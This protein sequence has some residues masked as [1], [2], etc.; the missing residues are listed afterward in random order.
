MDYKKVIYIIVIS[1]IVLVIIFPSA[2][3][4][5]L[6]KNHYNS[7]NNLVKKYIIPNLPKN[8]KTILDVGSGSGA[9][10]HCLKTNLKT[11]DI[12]PLDIKDFHEYGDKPLIYNGE[13][14]PLSDNSYDTLTCL[15][16]LHHIPN[17]DKILNELIRVS[18]KRLI[19]MEDWKESYLDNILTNIHSLSSYGKC[20]NC[21]HSKKE[22]KNIFESKGLKIK[23][24]INI[25]KNI[26]PIYPVSRVL[27]ILNK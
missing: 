5:F 7:K 27:F 4:K 8:N 18:K 12:L 11:N 1:I 26:M 25:P 3:E 23:K 16:V 24:M 21:F 9:I 20:Q 17:Q 6:R 13:N 14:I 15:S 10:A 2:L 19:I 22:W